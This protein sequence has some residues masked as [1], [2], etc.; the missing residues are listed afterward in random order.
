MPINGGIAHIMLPERSPKE[1]KVEDKL[2]AENAIM[3]LMM[4]LNSLGAA[5][6]SIKICLA[7]G[8][9]ILKTENKNIANQ[10]IYS[11]FR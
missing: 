6:T 10:I 2:Y 9:N 11:I 1:N 5:I 4:E 3:K 7:G 8:V